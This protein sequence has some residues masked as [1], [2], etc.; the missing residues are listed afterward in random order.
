[1]IACLAHNL[2]RWTGLL[3][4]TDATPRA[5]R[6]L[7]RRLL[8]LPGRL[9][10]TARRWTL[11]LPR[12]LALADRLHRSTHPHP[13]ARRRLTNATASDTRATGAANAC[14]RTGSRTGA[15]PQAT[16]AR[17]HKPRRHSHDGLN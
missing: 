10:R 16:L 8:A 2:A 9:T 11:H 12:A 4:L 13:S 1:V 17:P 3:G 6:T 15:H 14:P 5:A 7:R